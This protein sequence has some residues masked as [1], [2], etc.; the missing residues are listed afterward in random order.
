MTRNQLLFLKISSV[1]YNQI[2]FL[3]YLNDFFDI[4]QKMN[5]ENCILI[6]DNVAFHKCQAIRTRIETRG[7][8]FLFLPPYYQ[9]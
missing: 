4:L 2:S 8:E 6:M 5:L 3:G 9:I 1:P 7:H